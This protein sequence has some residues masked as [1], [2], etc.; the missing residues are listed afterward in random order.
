VAVSRGEFAMC[1]LLRDLAY[2]LALA[3]GLDKDDTPEHA[4]NEPWVRSEERR[5]TWQITYVFE[6]WMSVKK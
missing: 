4:A 3:L 2:R 6:R 5:R 1:S